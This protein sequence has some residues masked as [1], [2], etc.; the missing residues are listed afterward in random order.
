MADPRF[1]FFF[2]VASAYSWLA[3]SQV[4]SLAARTG[5]R[6]VWRPFSLGF[7]FKATGN[8]TPARIPAKAAW[9]RTD[10]ARWAQRHGLRH[11][12]P[13]R[14]PVASMGALRLLVA[15]RRT[16]GEA[17]VPKLATVLFDAAWGLD[18]DLADPLVLARCAQNAGLDPEPLLI[19]AEQPE[20]KA[21]LKA[22]TDEAVARGVFGAP[23][24]FVGDEL[25][26]GN[27][28]L[29]FVEAAL[30]ARA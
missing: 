19:A 29:D 1:E 16:V 25:F 18:L 6:C 20:T 2:D 8:E 4:E 10:I 23:A 7:A 24:F 9:L 12:Y 28:R 21:E 3:A 5:S 27:D 11:T 15:A 30:R 26:W 14:F 22:N 17:A 13:S